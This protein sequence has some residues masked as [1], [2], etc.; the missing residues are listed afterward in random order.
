MEQLLNRSNLTL[1][2]RGMPY[3]HVKDWSWTTSSAPCYGAIGGAHI[4]RFPGGTELK[5][6]ICLKPRD[7]R[8]R[9]VEHFVKVKE[10]K[11]ERERGKGIAVC[12][13]TFFLLWSA[14]P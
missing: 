8:P 2:T 9:G 1:P 13:T 10:K 5:Q 7:Y 12:V 3:M 11:R 6:V 4:I 14:F